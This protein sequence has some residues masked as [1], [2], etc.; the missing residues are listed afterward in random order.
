MPIC[1]VGIS[2]VQKDIL[3]ALVARTEFHNGDWS[4]PISHLSTKLPIL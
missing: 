3:D 2:T 1:F 4:D